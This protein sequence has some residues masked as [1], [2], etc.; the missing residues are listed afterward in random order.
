METNKNNNENKNATT[1]SQSQMG[2]FDLNNLIND[3]KVLEILKH[4]L[5]GGGAM[6]GSYFIWIKP[7]QDKIDTLNTKVI[8]Q[9]KKIKELED[10]IDDLTEEDQEEEKVQKNLGDGKDYFAIGKNN[11][12]KES[13]RQYRI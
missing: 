7:L 4:L 11:Q 9:D 3:P 12:V 10:T 6:A 5:S 1:S 2:G 8:E 13:K